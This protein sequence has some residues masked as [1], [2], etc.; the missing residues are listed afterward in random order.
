VQASAGGN[1][2]KASNCRSAGSAACA[3]E[4]MA[5]AATTEITLLRKIMV[6]L[7]SVI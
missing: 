7:N 2:A 4:K 6:I 3:G 5:A 1:C